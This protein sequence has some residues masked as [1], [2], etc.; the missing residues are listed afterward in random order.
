M[1]FNAVKLL[2]VCYALLL[3]SVSVHAKSVFALSR[4]SD[5]NIRVYDTV[6]DEIEF[7]LQSNDMSG[8][9]IDLAACLDEDV[10]FA[11]FDDSSPP[12]YVELMNSKTMESIKSI[13]VSPEMAGLAY[14]QTY[15]WLF[16]AERYG[17][18]IHVYEYDP[19]TQSFVGETTLDLDNVNGI[20]GICLDDVDMR[21]YV[22]ESESTV[23]YYDLEVQNNEPN[24]VYVDDIEIKLNGQDKIAVGATVY[25][26]GAGTKYLYTTGYNH[27]SGYQHNYIIRTSLTDPNETLGRVG[28]ELD[29]C[30]V[31]ADV[32][33]DTGYLYV[34]VYD[35]SLQVYDPLNW[36]ADPNDNQYTDIDTENYSGPAGVVVASQY[37]WPNRLWIQKKQISPEDP[38]DCVEPGDHI[39][40][41]IAFH[42]G[43]ADE[44]NVYVRD[45]LPY[46]CDF[47][48]AD[49]NTGTYDKESHVYEWYV[50]DISGWDPNVPG[51][52]NYYY[53]ITMQVNVAAEPAG[54]IINIAE[55][56]SEK[57]FSAHRVITCVDCWSPP[58]ADPNI[59]YVDRMRVFQRTYY[60]LMD[61]VVMQHLN[62]GTSW[63]DAYSDLN[64]ALARAE[65]GCGSE[66]WVA[67]G[68]Y[69][70]GPTAG[71][72]FEVPD[73]IEIYGGFC[74]N[75]TSRDQ[76]NWK[77]YATVLSGYIDETTRN[78]T[79]VKMGNNSL[80]DGFTV[81][82]ARD[83]GIYG[84]GDSYSVTNC[85][86]ANNEETGIY[87]ENG[88]LTVR[89]CEVK[90]SGYYGIHHE[91]SSYSLLAENCK[92]FD[93]QRNGI[94]TDFSTSTIINSLIYQNGLGGT[95]YGLNLRNPSSS[96][97][98]RN[99]TIVHN[100]NEGIRFV[101]SHTP[102]I[103][104][105]IVYYNNNDGKQLAGLDADTDADYC[106]IQDC[107]E[108]P[109]NSNF[110]DA[111]DF[112][113][114]VEPY[115]YYHI[116]YESPCRNGGDS[117]SYTNETDMDGEPR[118]A[119]DGVI[120]FS[121]F[122]FL[123]RSWL[124]RDPNDPSIIT[125][126]NFSSDPDYADPA[127][128]A[129]WE[130]AWFPWGKKSNLDDDYDVDLSDFELFCDN[131]LWQACWRE[132]YMAMY[133]DQSGMSGG[134]GDMFM[135]MLPMS[136]P[137]YSAQSLQVESIPV[138]EPTPQEEAATINDILDFLNALLE[139][140]SPEN[141]E[142]ILEMIAVLEDW[143]AEIS[144]AED[145]GLKAENP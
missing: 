10:I 58:G 133:P 109:A 73:G 1:K 79:V 71:D 94:L 65:K 12:Y 2:V 87:C 34:T 4:H 28:V 35:N 121:D 80:L 41:E 68:V 64:D 8:G 56:E 51:D 145:Y 22:C 86:V 128:L 43:Q 62:T 19:E 54:E 55:A 49:P 142:Q 6:G 24:L 132:N 40:Y 135:E 31:D 16:S 110:N 13:S 108:I 143:L 84:S 78:N 95:Y 130:Q 5:S 66:I 141:E 134:G 101:G 129:R 23:K 117:G 111:P 116:K 30:A 98:I 27:E 88:D 137:F 131:W 77:Q 90:N 104:N 47:V 57:A 106:C 96:P 91:G 72:S 125:D 83:Y 81:E 100:I 93:N 123:S 50:G 69:Q 82:E 99:N 18:G 136:E 85:I 7:Q 46:E 33:L 122:T 139:E 48:S 52:P 89:W 60:P 15:N 127:T 105:C 21:F 36:T 11:S 70:P 61:M 112:V 74:G 75:E 144:F 126:P 138:S 107:N 3:G 25:N 59:I 120:N 45:V 20:Y 115:G 42:P 92:I 76:R 124:S 38:N 9:A 29:A 140:E 119:D 32:D 97:T 114:S 113:Y 44:D 17:S 63:E 37:K 53:E 14:S 102:S 26:D 67:G 118:V 39:T 103:V